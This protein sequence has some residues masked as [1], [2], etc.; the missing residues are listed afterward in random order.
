MIVRLL[1]V[2]LALA[3]SAQAA[4]AKGYEAWYTAATDVPKSTVIP[5]KVHTYYDGKTFYSK[6]TSALGDKIGYCVDCPI[7][8]SSVDYVKQF[9]GKPL[10][11][12]TIGGTECVGYQFVDPIEKRMQEH[13]FDSSGKLYYQLV[14]NWEGTEGK[15]EQ[16]RTDFKID[17]LSSTLPTD[18]EITSNN[19]GSIEPPT[20]TVPVYDD[21]SPYAQTGKEK[22]NLP[23][24]QPP[25]AQQ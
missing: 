13:W 22:T 6:T 17:P 8:P 4:S 11:K 1:N 16:T 24:K 2:V 7:D 15:Y 9:G 21:R 3:L 20:E 19:S 14:N 12:R 18:P 23:L 10:G 25:A 5:A